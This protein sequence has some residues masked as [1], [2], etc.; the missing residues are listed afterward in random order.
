MRTTHETLS[1]DNQSRK[2]YVNMSLLEQNGSQCHPMRFGQR[3]IRYLNQGLE[4]LVRVTRSVPT[5]RCHTKPMDTFPTHVPSSLVPSWN[6]FATVRKRSRMFVS[7]CLGKG[8]A[9]DASHS[10]A[11]KS[12]SKNRSF[13]PSV[14][15]TL[16]QNPARRRLRSITFG[17]QKIIAVSDY[18]W[19]YGSW[20]ETHTWKAL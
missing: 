7:L 1:I 9:Q 6:T 17:K 3:T 11:L 5:V 12:A 20:I 8:S 14:V 13:R 18:H 16:G 10:E 15:K 19:Q 2:N 4:N